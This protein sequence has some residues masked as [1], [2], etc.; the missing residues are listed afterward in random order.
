MHSVKTLTIPKCETNV[1]FYK[2][3]K[4]L[5]FPSITTVFPAEPFSVHLLYNLQHA[6]FFHRENIQSTY[7]GY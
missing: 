6:I 5:V 1:Q 7:S 2:C 3:R 4:F